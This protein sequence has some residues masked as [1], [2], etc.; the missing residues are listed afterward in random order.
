MKS[1]HATTRAACRAVAALVAVSTLVLSLLVMVDPAAASGS[2]INDERSRAGLPPVEMHDGLAS[3]AAQ[4]AQAMADENRLYHSS[5]LGDR[6]GTKVPNW[7]AVAENVGM[8]GSL[9]EVHEAF[10]QSSSHRANVLGN[11]N[12]AGVA[13]VTDAE[14]QVW[15]A[16]VFAR[17]PVAAPAPAPAPAPS[18]PLDDRTT[19][20]PRV[21]RDRVE[22][23]PTPAPLPVPEI[24]G[25]T[26]A[27]VAAPALGRWGEGYY[28]FAAD[29]GVFAHEGADFAGSLDV[30]GLAEPVVGGASTRLGDGYWVASADGGVFALGDAPFHG[31]LAGD[32]LAAP[33]VGLTGARRDGYWLAS[34]DG[35]VFAFGAAAYHGGANETDL[36]RPVAA[37]TATRSGKGY[38]LVGED[39]GVFA[40]GDAAYHGGLSDQP[41]NAPVTGIATTPSGQGYWLVAADGG[42]FAFGDARHAGSLADQPL[43][44]PIRAIVP[45]RSATGYHLVSASGEVFD[46]GQPA[47]QAP[48][49]AY[50]VYGQ[51]FIR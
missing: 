28:L 49:R 11:F 25:Y 37:I 15:V 21:S 51:A 8:G 36:N 23:D 2:F 14:G 18:T 17:A 26:A 33:V 31:S 29:G 1:S 4:H 46:L 47:P 35:G 40:F 32:V 42:V 5:N 45:E 34:A 50:A 12:L 13:A 7:E 24:A 27:G 48:A 30:D 44:D 38:W 6:V 22:P 43:S 20:A 19:I 10:M 9:D 16:Q 39:G 41:L 3:L